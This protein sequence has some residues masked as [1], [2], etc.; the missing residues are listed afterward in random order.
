[1]NMKRQR[2]TVAKKSLEKSVAGRSINFS[3]I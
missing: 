3:D 1:M 2:H